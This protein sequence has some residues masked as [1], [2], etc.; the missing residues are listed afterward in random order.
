MN[1]SDYFLACVIEFLIY[2]NAFDI[3]RSI[4]E[5]VKNT[6]SLYNEF[7]LLLRSCPCKN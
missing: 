7:S 4:L 1:K 5:K 3:A 6:F 2:E